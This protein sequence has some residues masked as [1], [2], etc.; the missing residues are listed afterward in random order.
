[1]IT[2]EIRCRYRP[3]TDNF[4]HLSQFVDSFLSRLSANFF[5]STLSTLKNGA[6]CEAKWQNEF[7]LSAVQLLGRRN[8]IGVEVSRG[9]VE[10]QRMKTDEIGS[11]DDSDDEKESNEISFDIP[12]KVDFYING[13]RQWAVE[14][15]VRGEQ[16]QGG[17]PAVKEHS[18]RFTKGHYR[19]LPR[20]EELVIDFR[21]RTW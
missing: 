19:N 7:Y 12:G 11:S 10:G 21:R 20:K 6:I 1:M 15:L 13:K 4:T 9:S 5:Q 17:V 8:E 14:L 3:A 16:K 18:R 2:L